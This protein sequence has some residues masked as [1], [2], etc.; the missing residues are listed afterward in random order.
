MR[1]GA[2]PW[3][4]SFLI[5]FREL[6]G[7]L[8]LNLRSPDTVG[9]FCSA[10]KLWR[11]EANVTMTTI[12]VAKM[13]KRDLMGGKK[14]H[15]PITLKYNI[16]RVLCLFVFLRPSSAPAPS[17]T[18]PLDVCVNKRGHNETMNNK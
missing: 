5:S 14:M 18:P 17:P 2:A 11:L 6:R 15:A 12:Y 1:A 7:Q 13:E 4:T 16:W 8:G 9:A 3:Q 10:P